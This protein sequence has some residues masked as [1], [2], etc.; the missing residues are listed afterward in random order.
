M[1]F[2]QGL[3]RA[4]QQTP[5]SIA[6]VFGSRRQS[7]S[8]LRERVARLAGGLASLGY[9]RGDRL[10]ILSF[11]SDRYLEFYLASAWLGAEV[12]PVNF[13]WSIG[14][15][16]YSL[17]DSNSEALFLDNHFA[18]SAAEIQA[19]APTLRHLLFIG[20][21]DCPPGLLDVNELI[22]GAQP[23]PDS[24]V[25][26]DDT[27][28][29]FY[30]G[31]TTGKPKGV[32]LSHLNIA[33]SALALMAEGLFA[34]GTIA[35]HAAPMFHLA[36]MMVTASVLLR[37]GRHIMTPAF[38]P[39]TALDLIE[40]HRITDLLLVPTMLQALADC[41][42]TLERA[43]SVRSVLYGA[44]PATETLL[45]NATRA[46]P[47]ATFTQA[48][49]MTEMSAVMTVLP[50]FMNSVEG[51]RLGKVQ[52][53]G[54]AAYHAQVRI[55]DEQGREIPR[56]EVG[57]I[58]ARGPN[59]MKGYLNMPEA[60]AETLRNGWMHTGDMGYMDDDGYVF[61]VDRLKD[62]IISGGENIYC[63]EVENATAS[64]P[65][66]AACVVFGIPSAEWGEVV[67]AAIVLRPGH[68]LT[69]EQ[70][71]AHC[72]DRIA[73]YKCPRSLQILDALPLSSMGKVLKT[74]LRK[75]HWNG[76]ERAVN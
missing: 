6:T 58:V 3:H 38:R 30:T 73:S 53:G 49:G 48:Y 7:F 16:T 59:M 22:E 66:I 45:D 33:S 60:T 36:D 40:E 12:N 1:Q 68:S 72:R 2:T 76:R 5:E 20:E 37:G 74:E 65:A 54:R 25:G 11:N 32:I 14:E 64:H 43:S 62:M 57:E 75:A 47:G 24:G 67:H 52:S 42:N 63:V 56:G 55:V 51:R 13:R 34:E 44:S 18:G 15:I 69:L 70:L 23:I 9:G 29:I 4:V 39:D 61:I 8:Q 41:P 46:L 50:P 21:G 31:G 19:E 71:Q 28:G 27:F 17:N 26:G 35:L 10:A